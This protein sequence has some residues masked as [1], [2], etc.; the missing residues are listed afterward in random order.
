MTPVLCLAG[1]RCDRFGQPQL[2]CGVWVVPLGS[3]V[4]WLGGLPVRATLDQVRQLVPRVLSEFPSTTT[5]PE[6][7]AAIGRDLAKVTPLRTVER[8]PRRTSHTVVQAAKKQSSARDRTGRRVVGSLFRAAVVVSLMVWGV[9]HSDSLRSHVAQ[10]LASAVP[11][12]AEVASRPGEPVSAP[13]SPMAAVGV[14]RLDCAALSPDRLST[15]VQISVQPWH[16]E[17]GVCRWLTDPTDP[18]T[19]VVTAEQLP[20]WSLAS[21]AGDTVHLAPSASVTP[22]GPT[23]L[24]LARPGQWIPVADSRTET[25]WPMRVEIHRGPLGIDDTRGQRILRVVAADLNVAR[26]R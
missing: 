10:I 13:E 1:N 14:G 20:E 12:T 17:D 4:A 6:L 23:S 19:V 26:A 16:G 9:Q 21:L 18:M 2:V 3:L 5:D 24:L 7:L 11:G 22:P 8:L 15:Y 25:R